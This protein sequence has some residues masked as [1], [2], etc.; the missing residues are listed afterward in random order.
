[1]CNA[2]HVFFPKDIYISP[3]PFIKKVFHMS[4]QYKRV[5]SNIVDVPLCTISEEKAGMQ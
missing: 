2:S 4:Q 3:S 1:M 5:G